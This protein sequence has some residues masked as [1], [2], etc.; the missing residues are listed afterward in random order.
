MDDGA[1]GPNGGLPLRVLK[2]LVCVVDPGVEDPVLFG[3][4]K[5]VVAQAVLQVLGPLFG[6]G[7][8]FA[9]FPEFGFGFF[10]ASGFLYTPCLVLGSPNLIVDGFKPSCQRRHLFWRNKL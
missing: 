1:A 9:H 4:L 7:D 10:G 8:S 3:T 6:G 5:L 2:T